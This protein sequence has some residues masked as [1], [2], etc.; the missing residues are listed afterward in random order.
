MPLS[1]SVTRGASIDSIGAPS[2]S[3]IVRSTLA[4]CVIPW[5]FVAVPDTTTVLG[6]SSRRLSTAATVPV[7]LARPA[8]IVNVFAALSRKSPF[9]AFVPAAAATVTVVASLDG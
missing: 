9:A 8:A 1:P 7:L 3:V 5:R 6:A 2:S 4:G